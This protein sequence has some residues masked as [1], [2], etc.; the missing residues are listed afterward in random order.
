MAGK[1]KKHMPKR[2]RK[3]KKAAC[4][5]TMS[6]PE[7]R[8]GLQYIEAYAGKV[9]AKTD[10]MRQA[11]A[12]FAN[13]WYAV[14]QKK[15]S[16]DA[17][18]DYL[19][20]ATT[21]SGT[22]RKANSAKQKGGMAPVD[23]QLR[24][25]VLPPYGTF[26]PYVDKGFDVGVPAMSQTELCAAGGSPSLIPFPDTGSNVMKGGRKTRKQRG[27]GFM[28]TLKQVWSHPVPSNPT[29]VTTD[30]LRA[31]RGQDLGPG[32]DSTTRA[33]PYVSS[34]YSTEALKGLYNSAAVKSL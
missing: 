34:G 30:A 2:Y 26:L 31:W 16:L 9:L 12:D 20:H 1:T 7:L 23:Y 29:S 10:D 11:A 21:Y 18:T 15:L 28:D 8:T 24:A 25:G 4:A 13:E 32:P 6:L 14:F 5:K 33:Y 3:T 17:A 27:A 19:K 22:G